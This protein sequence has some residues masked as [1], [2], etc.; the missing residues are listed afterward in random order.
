[1]HF[2]ESVDDFQLR[3]TEKERSQ[4][5]NSFMFQIFTAVSVVEVVSTE[6]PELSAAPSV[7]DKNIPFHA[8]PTA[9]I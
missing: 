7:G 9:R 3:H 8:S 6:I 1:V 2:T 4:W 5:E